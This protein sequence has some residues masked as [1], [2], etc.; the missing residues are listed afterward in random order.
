M[1]EKSTNIDHGLMWPSVIVTGIIGLLLSLFPK[2]GKAT[3]DLLFGVLTHNFKWLFLLFGLF[4]VLFLIWLACSK[5]GNIKLG[6]PDDEPEFSTYAWASMIFCA[7][8]G[9]AHV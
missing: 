6:T 7:E 4:C 2:S 9:R 3:V 1:R 8:I 5:W